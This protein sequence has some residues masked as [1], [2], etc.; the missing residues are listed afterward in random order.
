M[1]V[2]VDTAAMQDIVTKA[3]FDGLTDDQRK[4]I[5]VQAVTELLTKPREE[6]NGYR[7]VRR[8]SP[9]QEAF[10][11]AAYR[12]A[13]DIANKQL[14]EDPNFQAQIKGL[15]VGVAEKLFAADVRQKL[16]DTIADQITRAFNKD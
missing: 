4:G 2:T 16:V 8:P 13:I 12:V 5:M 10:N 6:H 9:L 7:T 1:N 11:G 3:I 14:A 15:L